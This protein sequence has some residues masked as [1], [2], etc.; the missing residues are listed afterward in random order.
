MIAHLRGT[1]AAPV[2]VTKEAAQVVV[3]VHGV[4]Y[5]VFMP[6][7]STTRLPTRGEEVEL[8]TSLQV[9]EDS[10]TIYGFTTAD[11]R[12]LFELLLNAPGV[13]PKLA[14]AVLATHSATGLRAALVDGDVDALVLVPGVGRKLAQKLVLELR[15]RVGADLGE[16]VVG[17]AAPAVHGAATEVRLALLEL[18]YSASEAQRALDGVEPSEDH[19]ALLR[20]ALRVLAPTG[21]AR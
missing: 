11:S 5:R 18:G 3:D 13:G 16:D 2:T 8:H 1:V 15:E 19:A 9:R 21:V 6:S 14:L 4:G 7:S 17:S 10:M 20:S 12:D